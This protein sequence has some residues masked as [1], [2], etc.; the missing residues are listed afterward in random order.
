MYALFEQKMEMEG[1]ERSSIVHL[2]WGGHKMVT[3]NGGM[4]LCA[5]E[6]EG[7]PLSLFWHLPYSKYLEVPHYHLYTLGA[8]C[9]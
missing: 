7:S 9:V 1:D 3:K 8:I 4:K 6:N 2:K 5:V